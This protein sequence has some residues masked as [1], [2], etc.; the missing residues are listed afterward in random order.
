MSLK[1]ANAPV[2]TRLPLLM[3]KQRTTTNIKLQEEVQ[4]SLSTGRDL[5]T[6]GTINAT[7]QSRQLRRVAQMPKTRLK[8]QSSLP[9]VASSSSSHLRINTLALVF[10]SN[11]SST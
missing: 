7:M 1:I 6:N 11:L 3:L 10:A 2:I 9:T 8:L 5:P 4:T